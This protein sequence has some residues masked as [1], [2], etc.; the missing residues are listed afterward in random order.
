MTTL[1]ICRR[2][3]K[4]LFVYTGWHINSDTKAHSTTT[5]YFYSFIQS[6]KMDSLVLK[7][8]NNNKSKIILK[9]QS[10]LHWH[11]CK[12]WVTLESY[13]Q[14]YAARPRQFQPRFAVALISRHLLT[15][16]FSLLFLFRGFLKQNN[17]P[18]RG[19][20]SSPAIQSYVDLFYPFWKTIPAIFYCVD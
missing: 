1:A 18:N 15:K 12:L 6:G 4:T 11:W 16:T 14:F 9:I 8:L 19:L 13:Q 17:P 3:G 2:L 7:N 20:V 5:S 10:D